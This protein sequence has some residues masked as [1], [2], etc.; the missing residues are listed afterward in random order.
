MAASFTYTHD[1]FAS[2]NMRASPQSHGLNGSRVSKKRSM[3][4][5]GD[6]LCEILASTLDFPISSSGLSDFHIDSY[7]GSPSSPSSVQTSTVESPALTTSPVTDPTYYLDDNQETRFADAGKS[8]IQPQH[9]ATSEYQEYAGA[10]RQHRSSP[11][12]GF[13]LSNTADLRSPS[14]DGF[15]PTSHNAASSGPSVSTKRIPPTNTLATSQS[16]GSVHDGKSS[17]ENDISEGND[18]TPQQ[19]FS[20][21]TA[22]EN[23]QPTMSNSLS[24][25][26]YMRHVFLSKLSKYDSLGNRSNVHV[27]ID[28]SNIIISFYEVYKTSHGIPASRRILVPSFHF[29]VF[30]FILERGRRVEKRILAGSTS[31]ACDEDQRRYWPRHFI[32][33]E[34]VGYRMNIFGRVLKRKE[35][36]IKSRRKGKSSPRP[37]HPFDMTATSGDDMS[38][39][40]MVGVHEVRNGEQG[41]DEN[42]HLNMMDS[43][44]ECQS[45]PGTIVLATGDAAR[46][47]FSPGFLVYARR[48]LDAGWNVELVAWK[49]ALSFSWTSAEFTEKYP[50]RFNIIFLDEFLDELQTNFLD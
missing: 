27:F 48:L 11:S 30:A 23:V 50:G 15:Y 17:P 33:A 25:I 3:P 38:E 49:K 12:L 26:Q 42:L 19:F 41:V 13:G 21:V 7:T 29:K 22:R 4:R 2:V 37:S 43:L 1:P 28:M 10:T 6:G 47:E 14:Q 20:L 9:T 36:P 35:Y 18:T 8:S 39:D 44:F 34:N 40:G 31:S 32:E 16:L 45:N 24:S 46:A 5:L